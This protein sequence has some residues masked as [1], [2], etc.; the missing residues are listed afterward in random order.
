MYIGRAST[1]LCSTQRALRH[2]VKLCQILTVVL[3]TL[4]KMVFPFM[5]RCAHDSPEV[6]VVDYL[7]RSA[8]EEVDDF[9]L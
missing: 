7:E 9:Y 8:V 1:S 4:V 6:G 3:L 2:N 5:L